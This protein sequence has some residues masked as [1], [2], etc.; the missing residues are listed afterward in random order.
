MA[1]TSTRM[2][3]SSSARK[4]AEMTTHVLSPVKQCPTSDTEVSTTAESEHGTPLSSSASPEPLQCLM[5]GTPR[6]RRRWP[7]TRG[8][9][10][11]QLPRG[12]AGSVGPAAFRQ[13]RASE[14]AAAAR[15]AATQAAAAAAAL[16]SE[17]EWKT[18]A[19]SECTVAG[20]K[21]E[22]VH[23]N[24]DQVHNGQLGGA[25]ELRRIG[26]SCDLRGSSDRHGWLAE[27]IAQR[28]AG[29][30]N[31]TGVLAMRVVQGTKI[32]SDDKGKAGGIEFSIGDEGNRV[33]SAIG[34]SDSDED[35][36][37]QP[38]L[39]EDFSPRPPSELLQRRPQF[40][41]ANLRVMDPRRPKHQAVQRTATF[42]LGK[43][44]AS[45][46]GARL[47]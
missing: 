8:H 28:K 24:S 33:Q 9:S 14:T 13:W 22:Q 10:G 18:D 25:F 36:R 32:D 3:E 26:R 34:D 16:C 44:R 4:S 12:G 2:W 46:L 41:R 21:S 39:L 47:G 11:V 5:L 23:S 6:S 15:A 20:H 45:R 38:A 17:T 19:E 31:G 43:L 1:L 42:D 30:V 29:R 7:E 35:E 40:P 27:R 37:V